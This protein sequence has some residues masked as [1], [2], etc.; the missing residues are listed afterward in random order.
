[1]SFDWDNGKLFIASQR[2]NATHL[3]K[4]KNEDIQ[5]SQKA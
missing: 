4:L 3:A 1:M 5:N 2:P